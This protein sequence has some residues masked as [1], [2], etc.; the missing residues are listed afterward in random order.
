MTV[1]AWQRPEKLALGMGFGAIDKVN[2]NN[3]FYRNASS[4]HLI[5]VVTPT[6]ARRGDMVFL[7]KLSIITDRDV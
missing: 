2:W 7:I 5:I 4:Y 6:D 1:I 3:F